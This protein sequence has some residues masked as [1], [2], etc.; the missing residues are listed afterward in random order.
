L[1][2][3]GL[4]AEGEEEPPILDDSAGLVFSL[5]EL[6]LGPKVLFRLGTELALGADCASLLTLALSADW[7]LLGAEVLALLGD[8]ALLLEEDLLL[9][10]LGL[11]DFLVLLE[12]L[13]LLELPL[14]PT[15]LMDDIVVLLCISL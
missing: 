4:E 6:S 11:L 10:D 13:D 7:L 15:P 9:E 3:A 2:E 5:E 8:L 1:D 14:E 12:L